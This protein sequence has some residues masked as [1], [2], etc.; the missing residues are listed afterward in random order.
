MSHTHD[1][2]QCIFSNIIVGLLLTIFSADYKNEWMNLDGDVCIG[3]RVKLNKKSLD[4]GILFDYSFNELY[5]IDSKQYTQA[6]FF[7]VNSAKASEKFAHGAP[8]PAG[9]KYSLD[10]TVDSYAVFPKV[11]DKSNHNSKTLNYNIRIEI[12][13]NLINKLKFHTIFNI[14][15]DYNIIIINML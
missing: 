2:F 4:D 11:V 9:S 7:S 15:I 6:Y 14:N 5:M 3:E 12:H 8:S 10:L 13:S 1:D